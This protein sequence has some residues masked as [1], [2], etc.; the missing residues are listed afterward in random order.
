MPGKMRLKK[1]LML[2][3]IYAHYS[4]YYSYALKWKMYTFLKIGYLIRVN[5]ADIVPTKHH[6]PSFAT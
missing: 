1:S 4:G 3:R 5:T 2:S 6:S